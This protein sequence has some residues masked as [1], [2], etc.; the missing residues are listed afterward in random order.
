MNW[1]EIPF[2]NLLNRSQQIQKSTTPPDVIKKIADAMDNPTSVKAH[3]PA[4][5]IVEVNRE[6]ELNKL[7]KTGHRPLEKIDGRWQENNS[8]NGPS[9][10]L[11]ID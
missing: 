2:G 11:I 3:L 8:D 7:L 9:G 10:N 4:P 1:P 6:T 5:R